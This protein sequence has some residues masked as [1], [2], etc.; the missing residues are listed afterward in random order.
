MNKNIILLAFL[1]I[2]VFACSSDENE[3]PDPKTS[4]ED[5]FIRLGPD[6]CGFL[7]E[8]END[9]YKPVNLDSSF[10]APNLRVNGSYRKV[11]SI[12]TCGMKSNS[13]EKI[14]IVDIERP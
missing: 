3:N 6:D 1:S 14:R 12:L 2:F 10:M 8:I 11:G 13:Y 9:R 5:A 7:L 4:F